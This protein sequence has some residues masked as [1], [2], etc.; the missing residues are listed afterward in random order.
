MPDLDRSYRIGPILLAPTILPR[1]GW[2]FLVAAF[3]SIGLMI[4][5]SI[6]Q[7][8]ILNEHLGVPES[9]QGAISGN[10][11]F[12]TEIVTLLL[13]LPGGILMDRIGRRPVY[14]AGFLVLALTYVLYPLAE[15]VEALYVYR[16]IYAVG[17]VAVAGGL[18]TVLADYPAECSRGKLVA[19]VGF[20]SGL[21]VVFISQGFGALPKLFVGMGLDGVAAGRLAHF[22][23]AGLCV[24]VAMIVFWGLKPGIPIRHEDRPSV[25]DLFVGGFSHARNP[26]I[27]LAYLAAFIARGDQSVNATFLILWGTLAGKAAGL[28]PA[29]AVVSGTIIFVVAQIAALVWAPI[30]GPLLDRLDRVTAL[31]VCMG[32]AA[33]G[34]LALLV[35]GDPLATSG[36]VF[37]ILLGIGQI[38]VYLGGQSL[39]GQEAPTAQRGSVLGAFNVAGA[40]G[41]LIIT[42]VGGHLFDQIDPRAP[43]VVVGVINLLLL[44]A[45]VYVRVRHPAPVGG[46]VPVN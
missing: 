5:I 42:F 44:V 8:Y 41:I 37:F 14:V 7:T 40:I 27:L 12:L 18:S 31:A 19:M 3:F 30:L 34:N 43:F 1:H 13:F 17:V 11:V 25:R 10:L 33:L 46:G 6:G 21:G 23:V 4:F 38:S 9:I 24:I 26:R 22:I 16:L 28:E 20:L 35:L 45:S 39:I 2:T 15:S 36:I 29:A 32:L